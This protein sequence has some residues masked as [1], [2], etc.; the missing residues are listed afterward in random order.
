MVTDYI[1][2]RLPACVNG[3]YDFVDVRDVASGCLAALERGRKGE[4]YILSNRHYEIKD[5]L[6]MVKMQSGGRRL[7]VLPMW[8]AK[9][10]HLSSAASAG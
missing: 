7:P 1:E 10:R 9:W 2:G 5:V 6:K 8:M 4:C 3:G